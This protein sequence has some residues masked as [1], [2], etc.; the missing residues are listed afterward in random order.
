MR[1]YK[2]LSFSP[3]RSSPILCYE[4]HNYRIRLDALTYWND[5]CDCWYLVPCDKDQRTDSKGWERRPKQTTKQR[6]TRGEIFSFFSPARAF[7]YLHTNGESSI[8]RGSVTQWQCQWLLYSITQGINLAT[9]Q[10][11]FREKEKI[12]LRVINE[13]LYGVHLSTKWSH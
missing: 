11:L 3:R 2:K 5:R 1:P 6:E 12:L 9:V 8:Q 13:I 4:G 10:H 7:L